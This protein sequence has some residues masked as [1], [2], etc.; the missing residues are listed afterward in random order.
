MSVLVVKMLENLL[1]RSCNLWSFAAVSFHT[2][3]GLPH[4]AFILRCYLASVSLGI[5]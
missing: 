4:M 5:L 1:G 3:E 2:T